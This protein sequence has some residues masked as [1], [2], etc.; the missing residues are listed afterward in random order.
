MLES[1]HYDPVYMRLLVLTTWLHFTYLCCFLITLGPA[2]LDSGA[3]TMVDPCWRLDFSCGAIGSAVALSLPAFSWPT[4]E[5]LFCSSWASFSL[6]YIV[7][8]IF[9]HSGDVIFMEYWIP[10]CDNCVIVLFCWNVYYHRT[11]AFWF[12]SVPILSVH[13]CV[14][15]PCVCTSQ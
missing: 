15:P 2:C 13:K 6:L 7:N 8:H 3:W 1:H 5:I 9:A 4:L 10:L 12:L 14:F 11:F